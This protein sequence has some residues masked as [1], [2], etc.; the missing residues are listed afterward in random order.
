MGVSLGIFGAV[1]AILIGVVIRSRS[2]ERSMP[3]P[4]CGEVT[5]I[6]EPYLMCDDCQS[7]VGL[8][9]NG[10]NYASS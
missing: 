2:R 10:K 4:H 1:A 6:V 5:R 3:C 8:R 7:L 9:L